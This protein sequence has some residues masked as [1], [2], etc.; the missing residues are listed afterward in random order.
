MKY[1]LKLFVMEDEQKSKSKTGFYDCILP[2]IQ[3]G[4]NNG[5]RIFIL[6]ATVEPLI[7]AKKIIIENSYKSYY[8]AL[9]ITQSNSEEVSIEDNYFLNY[10]DFYILDN[11]LGRDTR[12]AV[13]V[14]KRLINNERTTKDIIIITKK[15]YPSEFFSKDF[16]D[17]VCISKQGINILKE[18]V[19][20][21]I[22]IS[23]NTSIADRVCI[24]NNSSFDF[25]GGH[26]NNI[27]KMIDSPFSNSNELAFARAYIECWDEISKQDIERLIS[28]C[29]SSPKPICVLANTIDNKC[30]KQSIEKE[31][32]IVIT[33]DKKIFRYTSIA[34]RIVLPLSAVANYRISLKLLSI[35]L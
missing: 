1:D 15:G 25:I 11:W 20:S 23:K 19:K 5:Q 30:D 32:I 31:G 16:A 22:E 3:S 35:K 9:S 12:A 26:L 34:F 4:I 33:P 21:L 27:I 2:A 24:Y 18:E 14:A 28:L 8:K 29:K 10:F 13:E 17:V 7:E 6:W